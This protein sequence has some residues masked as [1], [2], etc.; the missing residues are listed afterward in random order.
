MHKKL[1]F[2]LFLA[3][4]LSSCAA[5]Q[6]NDT[7]SI[8][9]GVWKTTDK[10]MTWTQKSWVA[11]VGGS[12]TFRSTNVSLFEMDET[13]YKTLYYGAVNN[14]LFYSYDRA[15]SWHQ[16]SGLGNKTI[17]SISIDQNDHCVIY[18]SEGNKVH[19]TED[20]GRNWE[21]VFI[22]QRSTIT[23][24]ALLTDRQDSSVV[25]LGNSAGD[26]MKSVDGGNYWQKAHLFKKKINRLIG[27]PNNSNMIYAD[28]NNKGFYYSN[29]GG[30][31]W[32]KTDDMLKDQKL[33]TAIRD[34]VMIKGEPAVRYFATKRGIIYT[35]DDG[36]TWTKMD[37]LLEDKDANIRSFVV[38]PQDR[39]EVY[40]VT[41]KIFYRSIDGGK[42]WTPIKNKS[43]R[44]G[45][46]L[47]LDPE[48]PNIIYMAVKPYPEK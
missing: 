28:V 11:A 3:I 14:G 31:D 33:G 45:W 7:S 34:V 19:K 24:D 2:L 32:T 6:K 40:Y 26:I 16:A 39:N 1:L 10:G 15:N 18:A 43:S 42:S 8:D 5:Q 4:F 13:D 9:G 17:R 38:N 25:Y 37:L 47:K 27:D 30:F 23:I 46:Y 48:K 12:Q 29:N 35:E 22:D 20:C 36:D 41:N 44:R 21:R